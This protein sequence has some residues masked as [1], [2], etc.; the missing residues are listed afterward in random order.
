[1]PCPSLSELPPPLTGK[2]GWPWTQ[3]VEPLP[4]GT[5][6]KI[7]IVTPSFNQAQFLEETIRS[8]LLQG[9]P[10]L[11]YMVIDGGSTDGSVDV[12][13]RYAPWLAFWT[14][15]PDRGQSDAINKGWQRATGDVLAYLNSDDTYLPG[16]LRW[17]AETFAQNPSLGL[18]YGR[19]CVIDEQSRVLRE[20]PVRQAS[21]AEVL[22]WSPSI[23]QPSIFV[24]RTAV[25]SVGF[26]NTDLHYTMD[27]EF[28]LRIGLRSEMRF[29][30]YLLATMRDHAAAKTARDPLKHVEEG[31]AVAEK[32]FTQTLP[33]NLATLKQQTLAVFCLRRA[34][35]LSRLGRGAEARIAIH[36][37]LRLHTDTVI[38]RQ[39]ATVWAMS[40]LGYG[41]IAQLRRFKRWW[42]QLC[43]GRRT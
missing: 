37:A 38:I 7:T 34:R 1:M 33:P 5:W 14:S 13:R 10:N 36:Q 28:S 40:V 27:Y 8:V 29:I 2:T 21:L 6:P 26:F 23:P 20:R 15:E 39:A 16:A 30:P 42:L 24:R 17:V 35:V 12:I 32:F 41:I 31:M 3:A 22:R 9:Y 18:V 4:A 11:E 43:M 25:E 19:V